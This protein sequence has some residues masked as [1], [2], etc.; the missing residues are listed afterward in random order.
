MLTPKP[1]AA[2]QSVSEVVAALDAGLAREFP[3]VLVR[4]EVSD[5]FRA[6][7]GHCYFTLKDERAQLR[8][9]LFRAAAA[10][11]PFELE[12]GLEL[13]AGGEPRM[14]APRGALQLLVRELEPVGQGALQLAFEQLRARLEAEGLFDAAQK[15]ALPRFPRRVGV[16]TSPDAAA[17]R[18]VIK[19]SALRFPGTPLLLSRARVQGAGAARELCAALERVTR[20]PEVDVVLLVRG[21]GS[22]ED[23]QA[24]NDEA[25]AR[26][27]RAARVPVVS[28]VGHEVDFTIA[29]FAA[30]ARA[31]TPS[32]AAAL[33]LP[34]RALWRAR[35]RELAKALGAR[36][37]ARMADARRAL[38]VRHA[39]LHAH[40]P[41][42]RIAHA[43]R[44]H[45]DLLR[46]LPRAV[47][48][49]PARV[50]ARL[51][52]ALAGLDALS[53]LAVLARGY[54]IARAGDG[55][56]V[57]SASQ[58]NPGDALS[59]RVHEGEVIAE[60]RALKN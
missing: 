58:L 50:R 32:A 48:R 55:A 45:A 33:A 34:D 46:R 9:V 18:D 25:L 42:A 12:D 24:F 7:S 17:L 15:R 37:E 36:L 41:A 20:A 31:P 59:V 39:R 3:Q 49:T 44:A 54:A 57:R 26:A 60:V 56:I 51:A 53:P 5:L 1:A 2:P 16:V 43:R 8:A 14:Y 28:G 19:V 30:D 10:R 13:V 23:L 22:L 47:Q 11:V 27:I 52:T 4:G 29:D 38:G 35:T 21:G 6:A 40:A